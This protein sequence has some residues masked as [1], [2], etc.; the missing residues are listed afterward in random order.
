MLEEK[1]FLTY[2]IMVPVFYYHANRLHL[3]DRFGIIS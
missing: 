3:L 1:A 2:L